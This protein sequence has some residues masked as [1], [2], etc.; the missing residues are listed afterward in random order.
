MKYSLEMSEAEYLATIRAAEGISHRMFDAVSAV[1]K[2]APISE[3]DIP[4]PIPVSE[5]GKSHG[6][7]WTPDD[8]SEASAYWKDEG[9]HTVEFDSRYG[10]DRPSGPDAARGEAD[11][12]GVSP[13]EEA[14]L[15]AKAKVKGSDLDKGRRA[16]E[17]LLSLWLRNFGVADAE[18]PDRAEAMRGLANGR[19]SFRVLAY[20]KSQGGLTYAIN[21]LLPDLLPAT[22]DFDTHRQLVLDL[23]GNITQVS[24]I[25]FPDLS[26]LYEYKDIFRSDADEEGDDDE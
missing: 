14:P 2:A 23:A 26:D 19:N 21:A 25:L 24:S 17:K 18:Q 15:P 22:V 3:D 1:R 20:V 12:R 9:V 13:L 11:D 7:P 6:P 10:Q 5:W 4:A 8:T 16:F